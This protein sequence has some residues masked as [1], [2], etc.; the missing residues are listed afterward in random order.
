MPLARRL[1]QGGSSGV[2]R[3]RQALRGEMFRWDGIAVFLPACPCRLRQTARGPAQH[4]QQ[5][6]GRGV[7]VRHGAH[8]AAPAAAHKQHGVLRALHAPGSKV[9]AHQP[10]H[11]LHP[12]KGH[13]GG[14]ALHPAG[15]RVQLC[16]NFLVRVA[17]G[18]KVEHL[19]RHSHGLQP[20]FQ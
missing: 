15:L 9:G 5:P 11:R 6:E 4:V 16:A 3:I 12:G 2:C 13:G 1:C 7:G 10:Q 14:P 19:F 18:T 17:H 20:R 8:P